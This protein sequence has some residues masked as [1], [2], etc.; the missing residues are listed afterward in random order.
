MTSATRQ[1]RGAHCR[2]AATSPSGCGREA[3]RG[4]RKRQRAPRLSNARSFAADEWP[5]GCGGRERAEWRSEE[6]SIS[7]SRLGA[8]TNRYSVSSCGALSSLSRAAAE[9]KGDEEGKVRVEEGVGVEEE[10]A[11]VALALAVMR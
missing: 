2:S 10:T 3:E 9:G 1:M 7:D 6:N 5:E 11:D 4:G 8:A